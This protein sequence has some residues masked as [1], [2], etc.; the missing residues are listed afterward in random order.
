M[1][2]PGDYTEQ[3]IAFA[4]ID[5]G[6]YIS[7]IAKTLG[8]KI[9]S[10]RNAINSNPELKELVYE[11]REELLDNAERGLVKAVNAGKLEAIKFVLSRLG[12]NRGYGQK[13]EVDAKVDGDSVIRV[14]EFPD[15]GRE[16]N[17][18]NGNDTTAAGTTD[19]SA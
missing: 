4:I 2:V 8:C 15:D 12:R 5:C 11:Q 3:E 14:Y 9:E 6:G 13:I 16:G 7:A 17:G 19:G 1:A 10:I 18:Q